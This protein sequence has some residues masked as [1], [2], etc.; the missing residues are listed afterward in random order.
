MQSLQPIKYLAGFM[1]IYHLAMGIFG[2]LSATW[3]AKVGGILFG[4]QVALT[5]QF[6]YLSKYLSAYVIAFG[7][8]MLLVAK[9][10][11]RYG[12]LIYVAIALIVIRV[13]QRFIFADQ[14]Q[15]AFGIGVDRSF[16][17]ALIV[18]LLALGL[19]HFRPRQ[20]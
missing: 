10:P 16:I 4:A 17:N 13:L 5:P 8:M 14:L 20:A 19:Y 11:V 2:T 9:D 15:A 18:A 3:A 12:K 7:L 6:A 1:G